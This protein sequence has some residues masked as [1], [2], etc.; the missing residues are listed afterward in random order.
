MLE[1]CHTQDLRKNSLKPLFLPK[2]KAKRLWR[3]WRTTLRE[4]EAPMAVNSLLVLRKSYY[5]RNWLTIF[6]KFTAIRASSVAAEEV[7]L[8]PVVVL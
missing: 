6:C 4:G 1:K 8:A 3:T 5:T 7:L 2:R